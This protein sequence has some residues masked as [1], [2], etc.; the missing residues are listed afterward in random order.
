M[1]TNSIESLVSNGWEYHESDSERLAIEL[2]SA[3]FYELTQ[4]SLLQL[5]KLSNHTIGEHLH[6]WNRAAILAEKACSSESVG[7]V[8]E[9]SNIQLAIAHY[10]ND[11]ISKSHQ[12]E[13]NAILGSD[14]AMSTY[15]S[16]KALL[17]NALA[18]DSRYDEAFRLVSTLDHFVS[19]IDEDGPHI[20]SFAVAN[21][22][23]ASRLID[24]VDLSDNSKELM[25]K[26]AHSSLVYW[27]RCG[28]WENKERALYLLA[29]AFN[30]IERYDQGLSYCREALEV[31]RTNGEEKVDEAFIHLALAKAY[32]GLNNQEEHL[33]ALTHADQIAND[34][35]DPGMD[36]W[37][38]EERVRSTV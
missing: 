21:N 36:K 9:A 32:L 35:N 16:V 10:M 11:D 17:A 19:R 37:Y 14:N 4:D 8:S 25:L 7:E 15:L 27:Q 29:L 18:S 30:R 28:A 6:D 34:W 24:E 33:K 2:E 31:I 26:S 23:I 13:I 38:Q 1:T 20:R 3:S 5:L 22:N 12:A